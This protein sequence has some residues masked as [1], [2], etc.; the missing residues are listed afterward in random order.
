MAVSARIQEIYLALFGRPADP[1]GGE[2]YDTLTNDG[3]NLDP[4]L[5]GP[6]RHSGSDEYLGRITGMTDSQIIE[7]IYNSLFGPNADLAG[8][9]AELL[10]L[11]THQNIGTDV[12]L[13]A[14]VDVVSPS[15]AAPLQTTA[16]N[17]TIYG[18]LTPGIGSTL[19]TGD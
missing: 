1:V 3:A 16:D 15:A 9:D 2:Y 7:S 12:N 8:S 11:V 6:S 18:V 13:T 10:A 19:P 17:D 4:I 14:N 5:T